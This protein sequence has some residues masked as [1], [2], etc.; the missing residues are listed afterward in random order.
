MTLRHSHT[1]A[2]G[3][4]KA[5]ALALICTLTLLTLF[6]ASCGQK[7]ASEKPA[8]V[9]YYTC[10]MHPSVRSQDPNAKCPICSMNLVPVMKKGTGAAAPMGEHAGH[11]GHGTPMP[12][13]PMEPPGT[14]AAD[15]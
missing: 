9:D 4:S 3:H 7:G 13:M 8:N 1:S 14:N 6:A 2:P 15:L 11:A 12:G 10:T 5:G